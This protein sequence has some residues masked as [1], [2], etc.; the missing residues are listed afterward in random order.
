[1]SPQLKEKDGIEDHL[2]EAL[3]AADDGHARYH[4]RE[5]LQIMEL[6]R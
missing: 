5:A 4:I 2:H 1:M 6:Y 3:D